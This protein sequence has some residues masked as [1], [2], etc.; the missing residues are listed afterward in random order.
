[1]LPCSFKSAFGVECPGCGLQRSV[2]AFFQGDFLKSWE[3]FPALF[4]I[5]FTLGLLLLHL[6]FKFSWGPKALIYAFSASAMV[7]MINFFMKI[8]Q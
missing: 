8:C 7:M 6:R 5:L 1:M 3:L 4:P 2:L